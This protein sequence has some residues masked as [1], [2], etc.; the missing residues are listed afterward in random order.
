MVQEKLSKV[1]MQIT[2]THKHNKNAE[3]GE[4][5]IIEASVPEKEPEEIKKNN[6]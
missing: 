2:H 3:N 6:N 4:A 5:K 1:K